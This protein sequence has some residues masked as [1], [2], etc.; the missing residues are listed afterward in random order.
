M[1]NPTKATARFIILRPLAAMSIIPG[2]L[3]N[4]PT[5][6]LGISIETRKHSV[7]TSISHLAVSM[8]TSLTLWYWRAP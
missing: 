8:N 1:L 6:T 3:V 4:R 7:V 2:S 5:A